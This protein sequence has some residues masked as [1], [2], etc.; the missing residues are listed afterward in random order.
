MNARIPA[1]AML[2]LLCGLAFLNI[3]CAKNA[4]PAAPPS[5]D[6]VRNARLAE[7]ALL[8]DISIQSGAVVS[9]VGPVEKDS[10]LISMRSAIVDHWLRVT[11]APAYLFFV[12]DHPEQQY[13]HDV[14]YAWVNLQNGHWGV[15]DASWWPKLD[16]RPNPDE[17]PFVVV[18]Q[19]TKDGVTFYYGRGGGSGLPESYR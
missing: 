18:D 13:P 5:Q 3:S 19:I 9:V 14:R 7:E 11:D 16:A 15:V 1:L 10:K 2:I 12:N 4:P 6:E 17:S 8:K